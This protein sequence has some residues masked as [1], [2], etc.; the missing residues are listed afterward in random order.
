M[1]PHMRGSFADELEKLGGMGKSVLKALVGG[2]AG[3][4]ALHKAEQA[5]GGGSGKAP[6]RDFSTT[7]SRKADKTRQRPSFDFDTSASRKARFHRAMHA[8]EDAIKNRLKDRAKGAFRSLT[9]PTKP[10]GSVKT[11]GAVSRLGRVAAGTALA[12]HLLDEAEAAGKQAYVGQDFS[13]SSS[14]DHD[15]GRAVKA[16]VKSVLN[17]IG[18]PLNL[19]NEG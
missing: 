6:G 4:Y 13:T 2:T 5:A 10:A 11:G 17:A 15:R 1:T 9:T 16:G 14:K 18:K 19:T 12:G 3:G 7:A 8:R